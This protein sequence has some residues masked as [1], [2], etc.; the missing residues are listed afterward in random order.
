MPS[1]MDLK[2]D[3]K[4]AIVKCY[5]TPGFEGLDHQV[6]AIVEVLDGRYLDL[7]ALEEGGILGPK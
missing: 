6:D 5:L 2:E 7:G 3:L 1:V 4:A